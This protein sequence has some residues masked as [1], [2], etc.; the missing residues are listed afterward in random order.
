MSSLRSG[1]DAWFDGY[2]SA[3]SSRDL[4]LLF[5]GLI[6]SATGSWAYNVALLAFVFERTHSLGWVG[7]S[8]LIR[9]VP[10]LVLSAYGGVIAERMERVRLMLSADLLCA[11]WQGCLAVVAA[12]GGPVALALVLVALTAST[13]VVYSPAVAATIPSVVGEDDLVAANALNGT[14]D[15]LVVIAGPAVGAALLLIGSP[16]AAFAVNAGTFVASAALVSRIRTRSRP[17]DV[18][19]E[20]TAGP[21]AQMAVGA[22][23]IMSLSAAR[24][25]VAFCA[26]VSFVYGTDTVLFVGVSEHRLG[27]GQEGFG[28]LLAGLGIGGV[29]MAGAINRLAA[30]RRLA[31]IIIAGVAGYTLPTALLAVT[32]SPGLAFALQI[33]RGASTLVVDV[34]AITS[35]QRAVP[36][37]Q[38]ARV[39]G[40]FWAFV[41][42]AISLGTV[43]A[44]LAVSGLGLSGGL[45]IAAFAPF[46]IGL[47]GFPSLLEIDR[48]AAAKTAAL[49][50]RV[51]VL[52][53]LGI[54]ATASRNVL[55]R[56]A[57][58]AT[59]AAFAAGTRIVVEGE[60]ADALYV[61]VEGEVEVT[62]RG[63]SGGEERVLRRMSAPSYFGEIGVLER[64]PRTATVTALSDCRCEQIDGGTLLEA[65][66]AAP[67][68]SALMENARSRLALTHPSRQPAFANE[69]GAS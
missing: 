9:F 22:R 34:L 20:G 57:G 63:E 19:E 69:G 46:G 30:S 37:D 49:E 41:L 15:N 44:P 27:T 67:P 31:P 17:V 66:A 59:E 36:S 13:N 51:A 39:F 24:T 52:E 29:L 4:R 11:L 18:T 21:L 65:L 56:L 55:E 12:T 60:Q 43:L 10:V 2:R 26:L 68:S 6:V 23:T 32:H 25:L 64:I 58:A 38:L 62:A 35:L 33:L 53:G 50:P 28:Y 54:F 45:L 8:G 42:A 7:A 3:L 61:L 48:G 40:V 16:A 47:L 1:L 5:G 14:I